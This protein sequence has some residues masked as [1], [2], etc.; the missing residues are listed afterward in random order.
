MERHKLFG[1]ETLKIHMLNINELAMLQDFSNLLMK[2]NN[3]HQI[4]LDTRIPPVT[5]LITCIGINFKHRI[6]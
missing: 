3:K 2:M 1:R 6:K 5:Q 4:P